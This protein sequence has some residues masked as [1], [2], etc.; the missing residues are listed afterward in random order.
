M[1]VAWTGPVAR[2]DAEKWREQENTLKAELPESADGL[3]RYEVW[4][5]E[6]MKVSGGQKQG[7]PDQ[8]MPRRRA[9]CRRHRHGAPGRSELSLGHAEFR[10]RTKPSHGNPAL[11]ALKSPPPPERGGLGGDRLAAGSAWRRKSSGKPE[12]PPTQQRRAASPTG[13]GQSV[14]RRMSPTAV[15]GSEGQEMR[16]GSGS[17]KVTGSLTATGAWTR[18][19]LVKS[20]AGPLG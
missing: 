19:V 14:S 6:S 1:G 18:V 15:S 2:R 12:A 10:A 7:E 16:S 8:Q 20:R 5:K 11:S 13:P 9:G 4:A 17:W 3:I